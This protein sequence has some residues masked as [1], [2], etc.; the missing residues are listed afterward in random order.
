MNRE[1]VKKRVVQNLC[2]DKASVVHRMTHTT[3]KKHVI[4]YINVWNTI[5]T[6]LN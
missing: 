3:H 6:M 1:Y 5:T 4:L 2:T